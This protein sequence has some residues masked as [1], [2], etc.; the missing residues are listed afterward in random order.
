MLL[1]LLDKGLV[2]RLTSLDK[3][4]KDIATHPDLTARVWVTGEDEISSLGNTINSLLTALQFSEETL[5][6]AYQALESRVEERTA[7]LSEANR[8][9]RIEIG[10]RNRI[11]QALVQA[12]DQALEA[13]RL[14]T[15]LLA[16]VSH[17]L[18]TPLTVISGYA[19][20]LQLELD[21]PLTEAQHASLKHI[22]E[23]THYLTKQVGELLDQARLETGKIG[24]DI[25][26]FVLT[27][28]IESIHAQMQ[29]LAQ[30]KGLTLTIEVAEEL[31]VRMTSD[32]VCL[33][34][35]LVNLI[36]N[37]LKFTATG[38]VQ[39]CIHRAG[40]DH[41][42]IKVIDTGPGIPAEAQIYIFEPFRQLDG[43]LT[44]KHG[45]VG[46][47]LSIVKQIVMLMKGEIFLESQ[48]G[49]G[50]I[51]IVKLPLVVAP[52]EPDS[53]Q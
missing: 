27:D 9:L 42:T 5:R 40:P 51:F 2:S 29:A 33:Q 15:E 12:R 52:E 6:Q 14:K 30:S 21:G 31:P 7:E 8:L 4:V 53:Q 26:T 22:I 17:E 37:A 19:E 24:L 28:I 46:L 38:S 25:T 16:K 13:S 34:Q 35:V 47:G 50:S 39:V 49:R 23:S 10:E 1:F 43:S 11:E 18:R 32:S 48:V 44:R 3:R 41:W 20:M 45:G 36:G